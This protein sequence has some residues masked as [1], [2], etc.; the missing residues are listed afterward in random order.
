MVKNPPANAGD[1]GSILGLGRSLGGGNVSPLQNSCLENPM[2]RGAWCAPSGQKE[3]DMS[4]QL[5]M[6]TC[7]RNQDLG[8][9]CVHC[10]WVFMASRRLSWQSK[11]IYLCVPTLC[12]IVVQSLSHVQLCDPINWSM[13]GFP[14]LHYLQELAQT[15]V[16][17]V[18]DAIWPSLPLSPPSPLP[19]SLLQHQSLF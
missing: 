6:H 3:S 17:W 1:A 11:E 4:E 9:R 13:P 14:V 8:A 5:G 15:H 2:N 10:Y 12:V 19:F 7:V 16:P 18:S